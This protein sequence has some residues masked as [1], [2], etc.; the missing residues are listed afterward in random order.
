MEFIEDDE[1]LDTSS[2][3]SRSNHR[4]IRS[5]SPE[6]L[7]QVA[8]D[9]KARHARTRRAD[10]SHGDNEQALLQPDA[11]LYSFLVPVSDLCIDWR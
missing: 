3:I 1:T 4:I 8:A 2:A 10:R 11:S 7:E 9:I 6:D 5:S